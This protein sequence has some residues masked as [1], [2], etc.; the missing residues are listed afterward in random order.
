[1]DTV[2]VKEVRPYGPAHFAGLQNG[3]R[4]LTVNGM[5]VAGTPY[6]RV[7]AAIQQAPATLTLHVVPKECDILQTVSEFVFKIIVYSLQYL[8][9]SFS[10]KQHTTQKRINGPRVEITLQRNSS[11][12]ISCS[13]FCNNNHNSNS[14]SNNNIN[15][16]RNLNRRESFPCK[17][18]FPIPEVEIRPNNHPKGHSDQSP[19]RSSH[20]PIVEG[21]APNPNR[22]ITRTPLTSALAR[23]ACS[24]SPTWPF[25]LISVLRRLQHQCGSQPFRNVAIVLD[26]SSLT[27][28]ISRISSI[29]Q[30]WRQRTD[31]NRPPRSP[32]RWA[33][34]NRVPH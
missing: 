8:L 19:N 14:C 22:S 13:I 11:S 26:R 18:T 1:M 21:A 27:I 31:V 29:L 10:A 3:D 12:N 5:P 28:R 24:P 32:R 33:P 9:N 16:R 23:P 2:F 15:S 7:V 4:L 20:P 25:T 17:G 30:H 6:N 34:T